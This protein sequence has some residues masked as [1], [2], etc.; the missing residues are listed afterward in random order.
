MSSSRYPTYSVLAREDV[1]VQ[2]S[3]NCTLDLTIL[4][5][6]AEKGAP[7]LD[8]GDTLATAGEQFLRPGESVTL[9]VA[10]GDGQSAARDVDMYRV[11]LQ[12]GETLLCKRDAAGPSAYMRVFDDS[13]TNVWNSY[14][15]ESAQGYKA[16]KSGVY[17]VGVSN[18]TNYDPSLEGSA[19]NNGSTGT[20]TITLTR[21]TSLTSVPWLLSD[22]FGNKVASGSVAD[23]QSVSTPLI[24]PGTYYLWLNNTRNQAARS[25]SIRFGTWPSP[26]AQ[27]IDLASDRETV[28]S[29]TIALGGQTREF[30]LNVA[31]AGA[32]VLHASTEFSGASWRLTGDRER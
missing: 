11:Y 22:A 9:S 32:W 10:L 16:T 28:L 23:H 1:S 20:L 14:V 24:R 30:D 25:G 29:G 7:T 15:Y 13:A 8:V 21:Q 3:T 4:R 19:A 6:A 18:V 2:G 12:A 5:R 17:W 26:V 31:S 27:A